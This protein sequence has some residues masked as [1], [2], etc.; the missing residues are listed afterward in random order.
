MELV[1]I[2]DTHIDSI[3]KLPSKLID[4]IKNADGVIHTGDIT[5]EKVLRDLFN[6]NP[7]IYAVRGNMDKNLFSSLPKK[8]LIEIEGIKIGIT[9][10][11]TFYG[12]IEDY[13]FYSFPE[14]DIIIHGHTHVPFWGKVDDK[15]ILNPGSP[16]QNR[17]GLKYNTYAKLCI[18]NG[19]FNAEII[20]I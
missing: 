2:S 20:K 16:L 12:N 15:Y 14:A 8:R 17:G 5:S 6:L 10:G 1:I 13:L 3:E 18:E 7:N 9:H 4:E 19:K 11:D